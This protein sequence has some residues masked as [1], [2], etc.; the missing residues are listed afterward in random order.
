MNPQLTLDLLLGS[1]M[2]LLGASWWL[3]RQARPAHRRRA[4]RPFLRYWSRYFVPAGALVLLLAL[5]TGG[6]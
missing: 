4:L 2:G 6:W 3:Q 1:A 5:W